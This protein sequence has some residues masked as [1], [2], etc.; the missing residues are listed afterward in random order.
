LLVAVALVV[1]LPEPTWQQ[2]AAAVAKLL[3]TS[4]ALLYLEPNSPSPLARVALGELV[5]HLLQ[6]APVHQVVPAQLLQMD[7]PL[8]RL[9]EVAKVLLGGLTALEPEVTVFLF[10]QVLAT[11]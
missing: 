6:P 7:S 9:A 5:L 3:K 8:S 4:L 11:L 1:Q 2:V 10:L